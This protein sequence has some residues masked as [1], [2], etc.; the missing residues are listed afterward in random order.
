MWQSRAQGERFGA[1]SFGRR[2]RMAYLRAATQTSANL[3]AFR[4]HR[5]AVTKLAKRGA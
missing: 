2:H 5:F 1:S 3:R 4:Q